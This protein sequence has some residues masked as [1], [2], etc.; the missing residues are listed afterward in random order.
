[1]GEVKSCAHTVFINEI[2]EWINGQNMKIWKIVHPASLK[3]IA[4]SNSLYV[5]TWNKIDRDSLPSKINEEGVDIID[6]MHNST[7]IKLWEDV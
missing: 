6:D 7:V 4:S 2:K 3:N 5:C 1:M